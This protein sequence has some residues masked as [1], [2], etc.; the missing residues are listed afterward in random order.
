SREG[1]RRLPRLETPSLTGRGLLRERERR[2]P[3]RPPLP[4]SL[5]DE[6][7]TLR[8]SPGSDSDSDSAA[9]R[10]GSVLRAAAAGC[11]ILRPPALRTGRG[12]LESG[13]GLIVGPP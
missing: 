1:S 9:R 7:V 6:S 5:S 13:P 4:P 10:S 3:R 12:R 11:A 8:L 2:S